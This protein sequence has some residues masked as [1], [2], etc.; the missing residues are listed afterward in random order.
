MASAQPYIKR[1]N[2][3]K[4]FSKELTT[5]IEDIKK[6]VFELPSSQI[7]PV[8]FL[9]MGLLKE[10]TMLYKTLILKSNK[11]EINFFYDRLYEK[12]DFALTPLKPGR[13]INLSSD[14]NNVLKNADKIR[15]KLSHKLVTTA[16]VL[17]SIIENDNEI[18]NIFENKNITFSLLTDAAKEM[19]EMTDSIQ[20]VTNSII[21]DETISF[22]DLFDEDNEIFM[23]IKDT[24]EGSGNNEVR[25][26]DD[27]S[28]FCTNLNKLS[29]EGKLDK[30]YGRD[31]EIY[32]IIEILNRRKC[33]NVVIVG[34]PGVG[35]TSLIEGLVNKIVDEDV[36]PSMIDLNVWKL[37]SSSIIAGTQ[38]R[39]MIEERVNKIIAT[40]KKTKNNVL[41]ID[42]IHNITNSNKPNDYDLM[43][44]LSDLLVG[45]EVKIITTTNFKG[46]KSFFETSNTYQSKFQ[47]VIIE[48]PTYNECFNILMNVKKEYEKHHKVIFNEDIIRLCLNLSERYNTDKTLPTSAIDLMDEVG[49]HCFL[50]NTFTLTNK[51][52]SEM[53]KEIQNKMKKALKKDDITTLLEL[54]K[55]HSQLDAN[56]AKLNK[57][58]W[59]KT[60]SGIIVTDEDVYRVVS[61]NTGIPLNKIS[62]NDN[63]KYK[64]IDELLKKDVIGQDDAVD[65]V[66]KAIKRGKVGLNKKNKPISS[67][68]FIGE[69]GV[70]KTY[71]AKKIAEIV[72]GDEKYLV[73]LDMSEYSDKT[74]KNKL[75]GTG[76]GYIGYENGGLL[77]E[78]VKKQKY[79]VLLIDEIEKADE[80][81]YNTFLQ[82]LDEGNLTDNSGKKVD[83]KNTVIIMTS[84]IGTKNAS[85]NKTIGFNET[86]EDNRKR[87]II[88]KELKDKFPPEFL[89]RFDDIIYFNK[90]TNDVLK[91]ITSIEIEKL[92]KSMEKEGYALKTHENAIEWIVNKLDTNE[93]FGA[94]PI[95]RLIQNEIENKLI[96]L[97]IDDDS[98]KEF[99]VE[100]KNN[101]LVIS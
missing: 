53:K 30:I 66:A 33:N 42:D 48:K 63:K 56:I 72:F 78:A 32:K 60:E 37:N 5:F 58:K 71:L 54:Q 89:N 27:I 75:I 88:E 8:I 28:N 87:E 73:R 62:S 31:L 19:H 23:L 69:S 93:N 2:Y 59:M 39:G 20:D 29:K 100:I 90:L 96:D 26:K 52:I 84:N 46:Y 98:K 16:H 11:E 13:K 99:F 45:G 51:E 57:D 1:K 24:L 44:L 7:T 35:K 83:F 36:P 79:C 49:S 76:S 61:Q 22:E 94:R 101:E 74:S 70:G 41:F 86:N 38:F 3:E 85:L 67:F 92:G 21:S 15:E 91:T 10:D 80:E 12:I 4:N 25:K 97:I 17:L 68:M 55:E 43:S 95:L 18:K 77:T 50:E 34:D 9:T 64:N 65:K 47:K 14:M 82:V 40:L 6:D 81:I